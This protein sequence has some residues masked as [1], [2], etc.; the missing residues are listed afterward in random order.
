MLLSVPPTGRALEAFLLAR[1]RVVRLLAR[2]RAR[3]SRGRPTSH[4]MSRH[5]NTAR[6]A[7]LVGAEISVT[8]APPHPLTHA[9]AM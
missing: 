9:L 3:S 6:E 7:G 4:C 8:A 5:F 1:V 2:V